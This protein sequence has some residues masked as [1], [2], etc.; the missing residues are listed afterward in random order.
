MGDTFLKKKQREQ[1]DNGILVSKGR[2]SDGSLI[3]E[4]SEDA[5]LDREPK[6]M[7]VRDWHDASTYGTNLLDKFLPKRN[8]PFPNRYTPLKIHCVS[9]SLIGP[10]PL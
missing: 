9:I 8:F 6:T 5:E 10:M 4:W 2:E 1:L 3:L 7:W